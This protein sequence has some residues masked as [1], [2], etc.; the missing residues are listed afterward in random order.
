[1]RTFLRQDP[2][3]IMVGEIRD[4]ET[5]NM[6]VRAALTGHLVLSTI[7]TNSA[8]G[9]V[10]RLVDMGVPA[11]MVANTLNTSVAQRLLRLLC[12]ECKRAEVLDPG[13]YPR[14]FKP[15]RPVGTHFLAAGC[16]AC[17]FTGYRGRQAVYE[18]IPLDEELA[19][20]LKANNLNVTHL[21][22]ERGI[23]SLAENAFALFER[24]ETSLE[25]IYPLL[26]GN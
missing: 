11:Y 14:R 9:T 13:L 17:H 2:D 26:F 6:A 25:E 3:I 18:V 10:S 22:A 16:E 1:L 15:F 12:P 24:G 7:H 5:A 4:P 20:N 8:W 21:L 23:T 19:D